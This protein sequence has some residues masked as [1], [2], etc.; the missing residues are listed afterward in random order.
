MSFRLQM[1]EKLCE[2]FSSSRGS[3]MKFDR[4]P[5]IMSLESASVGAKNNNDKNKTKPNKGVW[6][7]S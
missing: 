5:Q 1:W 4:L 3:S 7:Q 2:A 6:M